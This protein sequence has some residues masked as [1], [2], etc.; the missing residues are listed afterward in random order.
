MAC[1]RCGC[2]V[3]YEFDDHE[4]DCCGLNDERLERCAACGAVFDIEDQLPEEDDDDL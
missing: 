3:S 2:K 4:D 1:P